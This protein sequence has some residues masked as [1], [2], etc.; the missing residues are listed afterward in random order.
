MDDETFI[1]H[2]LNSLPQTEYEGAMLGIKDKLRKGAVH[3]LEIEQIL[4]D[5]Y[6]SMKNVKGWDEEE[7]DYALFTSHS[8]KKKP[9]KQ[10][11]GHCGYCGEF[12]HK[13]ADCPNKKSNQNKGPKG[14]SEQ[15]KKH[16]TKGEYKGKG[17]KICPKLSVTIV[18]NMGIMHMTV[19]N[20]M[21]MLILLK[22]MSKTRN[23]RICWIWTI[24][25]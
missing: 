12:G 7:D 9:K 22:D 13:A 23:S 24:V 8:N 4:E 18:E 25:A 5:K 17:H 15:K 3:L 1:T 10:F 16:S 2:L 20:H 21:R 19:Q 14:R 11:K 6:Q